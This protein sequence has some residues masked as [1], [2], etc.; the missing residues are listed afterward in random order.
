MT[1]EKGTTVQTQYD[2][3]YFFFFFWKWPI[4]QALFITYLYWLFC[5]TWD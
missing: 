4:S 3:L 1:K 5:V 2:T